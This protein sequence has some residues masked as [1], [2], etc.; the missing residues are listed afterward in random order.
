[1]LPGSGFKI[2][3]LRNK[4]TTVALSA[5]RGQTMKPQFHRVHQ[6]SGYVCRRVSIGCRF[7]GLPPR[8]AAIGSSGSAALGCL[9][10]S[11]SVSRKLPP[12]ALA[13]G[14]RRGELG[15]VAPAGLPPPTLST[16][17]ARCGTGQLAPP[18]AES[19]VGRWAG[20]TERVRRRVSP[21]GGEPR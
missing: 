5:Y 8:G 11:P 21:G 18:E 10:C 12:R 15:A 20:S 1:M 2:A 16:L 3:K 14:S 7:S 4:S 13:T 6:M 17:T 19:R 9:C